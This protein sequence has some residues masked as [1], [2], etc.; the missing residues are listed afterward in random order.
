MTND[1]L[2][3]LRAAFRESLHLSAD[4]LVDSLEY[5]KHKKWDSVAH[6]ALV[7][8]IE[9][10]FDI[11]LETDDVLEMSSFLKAVSIVEKYDVAD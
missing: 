11:M 8:A 9:E 4:T 7:A 2:D 6:M 1:R 3:K 10:A 5:N